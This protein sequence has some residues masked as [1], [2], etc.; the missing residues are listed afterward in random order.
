[1]MR[2]V[3]GPDQPFRNADLIY[4]LRALGNAGAVLH[5]GS[6]P[7]DE[8]A[9]LMAFLSRGLAVRAVYWSATRGEGGQNRLGPERG[10]ALGIL[11]TWESLDAREVDGGEVLYGP[12]FDFGFSRSGE[13][14]LNRW[15]REAVVLEI[16][17][18]IRSVQ[19]F[20]VVSRW[21]GGPEDGHGQHQAIGLLVSE[22]VDAAA[23]PAAVSTLGARGLPPWR[24]Q[25]LYRSA[26]GDWTPGEDV[27]FGRRRPEMERLDVLRINTG[28][29]DPVSGRSYQELA[30][31]GGNRHQS[32]GMSFIPSPGDHISYYR[33]DRSEVAVRRPE[34]GLFDGLDPTLPGMADLLAPSAQRIRS[35]LSEAWTNAARAVEEFRPDR[36]AD[37][38]ETLLEGLDDIRAARR[39]VEEEVDDAARAALN[40]SL[41]RKE[42][43]FVSVATRCLGVEVE[44]LVPEA[45]LTPGRHLRTEVRAWVPPTPM[46]ITADVSLEV[47]DGWSVRRI[48]PAT[49]GDSGLEA[50]ELQPVEAAAFEVTIP[51]SAP[52]S[53]P[54]WLRKPQSPYRYSWPDSGPVGRPFDDPPISARCE[55]RVGSRA[56]RVARPAVERSTI[57]GGYR[58]L[59]PQ[60]VPPVSLIPRQ[61]RAFLPVDR[62]GTRLDLQVAV[63]SLAADVT[64]ILAVDAP[65][66]WE[67]HPPNEELA[68]DRPGDLRMLGIEV[69]IPS[70]AKPGVH[71]LDYRVTSNGRHYGVV[72]RP[73]WRRPP[74][75]ASAVDETTRVGEVFTMAPATT[76]I[77]LIEA[78]F[79]RRLRYGY[80]PGAAEGILEALEHFGLDVT[81]VA[82]SDLSYTD[83]VAFD[84]VV[85]G[86]NAYLLS[87]DVRRNAGR[88]LEYVDG[89]GTLVV[90]Y[91]GY[92]YQRPGLAPYP[93][94]Y[95]QPHDRVTA[96]DAPVT[97]LHPEHPVLTRPNQIGPE[98]F[99]GW[100][101]ERGL[102]FF[103]EWDRRYVPLLESSDPGQPPQ[104][105]GLLATNYGRGTFVYAAYAF[106]RQIPEGVPGA[107]RLFANLLG[108]AEARILDRVD[109]VRAIPLFSL[110]TDT[111]LYEVAR[112]MS[113]QWL[114]AEA[115]LA[116][117]GDRGAELY[118]IAEGEVEVVKGGRVVSVLGPGQVVGELAVMTDLPRAA[119][120]QARSEVRL[121]A[122]H[123][124]RFR[125]FLRTHPELMEGLASV[126]AR[127]LA[128]KEGP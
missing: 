90:Q 4:R 37:V 93:F 106:F 94:Q 19:P 99:D 104:R 13:D 23:D 105:G 15:G 67:V 68:F 3:S 74:G 96:P 72:L 95:R 86:P 84:T 110:M 80:I 116:R 75:V 120:L 9:G 113:E 69:A 44:C 43:E 45:R 40:R 98:D 73:V 49:Q 123:G 109:R 46:P 66:G 53:S 26:V 85:V 76:S 56:F 101:H 88:L 125:E 62:R 78:E 55:L 64:G 65:R 121:L 107:F 63:R 14:C 57:P 114:E 92:G 51:R 34:R 33:L 100:V 24:V 117:E 16:V 28:M 126:L 27:E 39:A 48:P 115:T 59:L 61:G 103:G 25:K 102:Y 128:L 22:A 1:M 118:F 82:P 124:V 12:F 36:P 29:V 2:P 18:A 52:L 21:T 42:T 31:I 5:L 17:R 6:H 50:L 112:L 35:L 32:Q 81:V 79:V 108:L 58:E 70:D 71:S 47:P 111:Q 8:D 119:T 89:G 41:A 77:N 10:E 87:D 38:V 122:V 60:V 54:Y 127:R 97:V 11:R 20:V 30:W 83:L 7:D 91:Q